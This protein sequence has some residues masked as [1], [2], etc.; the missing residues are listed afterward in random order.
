[1]PIQ[2]HVAHRPNL[3]LSQ[4][5]LRFEATEV[6]KTREQSVSVTNTGAEAQ[7]LTFASSTPNVFAVKPS[8]ARLE[9]G[10]EMSLIATFAP[11]DS[12]IAQGSI[13]IKSDKTDGWIEFLLHGTGMRRNERSLPARFAL[14]QNAPNPFNPTTVIPYD[15][16][17]PAHVTLKLYSVDGRLVR[18]LQDGSQNAGFYR[19]QWDGTDNRGEHVSSGVYFCR[20]TAGA[21][22]ATNKMVLL[23]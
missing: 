9:A 19:P 6:G 10:A 23:K 1:M 8:S 7:A 13:R 2:L 20:L 21:F 15:L 17:S 14:H 12:G 22:V 3:A 4:S 5:Q 16:P 18:T 11:I